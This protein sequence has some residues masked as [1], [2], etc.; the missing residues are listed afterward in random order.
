MV[1]VLPDK[2]NVGR[3]EVE[4]LE[5]IDKYSTLTGTTRIKLIKTVMSD[6]LKDKVLDNDF[7]ELPKPYYFNINELRKNEIV[8]ATSV[9]PIKDLEKCYI[10]FNVPN[11]LDLWNEEHKSYCFED[12]KNLHRGYYISGELYLDLVF[13]YNSKTEELEI[14]IANDL[15]IYFT[16]EQEKEKHKLFTEKEIYIPELE[17]TITVDYEGLNLSKYEDYKHL[18]LEEAERFKEQEELIEKIDKQEEEFYKNQ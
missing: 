13:S 14:A 10:L 11:N 16:S 2:K 1:K 5:R 8:K 17:T 15:D 18:V 12:N 6:F 3:L 9:K 7:I 4:L